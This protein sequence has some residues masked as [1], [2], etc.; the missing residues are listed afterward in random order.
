MKITEL[1]NG[2]FPPFWD[3]NEWF[4]IST[5]GFLMLSKEDESRRTISIRDLG[6]A[7]IVHSEK[8]LWNSIIGIRENLVYMGKVEDARTHLQVRNLACYNVYNRTLVWV[9][10]KE[11]FLLE[12]YKYPTVNSFD[13]PFMFTDTIKINLL[14][15]ELSFKSGMKEKC[16]PVGQDFYLYQ[17]GNTLIL[18]DLDEKICWKKKNYYAHWFQVSKEGI[19]YFLLPDNRV[20]MVEANSGVLINEIILKEIKKTTGQL[21]I[22]NF[23]QKNNLSHDKTSV[24]DV[25]ISDNSIFWINANNNLIIKNSHQVK[26]I[27]FQEDIYLST[28]NE[29]YIVLYSVNDGVSGKLISVQWRN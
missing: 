17:E 16:W 6:S 8:S 22:N 25:I 24:Y 10:K 11:T 15:G 12:K 20:H 18:K 14:N 2:K 28:A 21:T 1:F 7:S 4:V 5:E 9:K 3:L 27:E 23:E 26:E 13:F 29:N 19:L